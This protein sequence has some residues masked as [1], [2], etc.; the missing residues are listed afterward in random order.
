MELQVI[1]ISVAGGESVEE[2]SAV[3]HGRLGFTI[4]MT[5][6]FGRAELGKK[7]FGHST[8]SKKC[9]SVGR[10]LECR[11]MHAY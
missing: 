5:V 4:R 9:R 1:N 11:V 8:F 7:L 10:W 6:P 2:N 3:S